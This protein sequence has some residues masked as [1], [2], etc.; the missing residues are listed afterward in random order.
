MRLKEILESTTSGAIATSATP[1][2][3]VQT[4]SGGNLLSGKY[5]NTPFT[6]AIKNSRKKRANR[7]S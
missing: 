6:G 3:V 5:I 1:V 4:R 7:Q 2:G